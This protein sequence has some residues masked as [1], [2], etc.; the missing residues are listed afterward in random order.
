MDLFDTLET[1]PDSCKGSL[2]RDLHPDVS[3]VTTKKLQGTRK[4]LNFYLALQQP[5]LYGCFNWMIQQHLYMGNGCLTK[6]P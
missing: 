2:F 4:D 5:V 3:D 6:H 1:H